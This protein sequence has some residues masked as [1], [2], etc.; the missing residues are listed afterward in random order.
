MSNLVTLEQAE[1]LVRPPAFTD[2]ALAL[3]FAER[4][5]DDLRFVAAWGKWLS[6]TGTHWKIDDTLEAFDHARRVCR[7]AAASCNKGKLASALASAKTVAA[8]ERLAR[9]DRRLAATTD[10]WDAAPWL[11]NTPSG[12]IDLRTGDSILLAQRSI[13][14]RSTAVGPGGACPRFMAFLDT[15]TDHDVELQGYL[16]PGARL[17][18]DWRYDRTCAGVRPWRGKNGKEC[19]YQYCLTADGDLSPR[20]ADRDLHGDAMPTVTRPILQG[21]RGARLVTATE[22]EEGRRWAESRIKVLTG[23][24]TITRALHATGFLRVSARIQALHH[25][26]P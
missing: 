1:A 4:H 14:Q 9:A 12:V 18:L 13:S 16:Q 7:D 25:R 17:R 24:D 26:Q 11:L 22:T 19:S 3:Q 8:V 23:G 10:Q 15:I 5:A 21:L 20:R 6:Y 2:E